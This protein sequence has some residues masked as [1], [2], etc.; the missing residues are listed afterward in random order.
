MNLSEI[1]AITGMSGL[2][3][4]KGRRNDG[5]IVTSLVDGKTQFVSG[6][7]HLFTTLDNITLYTTGEPAT[8]KEVLAAIKEKEGKNALPDGKDDAKTKAWLE[9]VLPEYD[10]EKVYVSDMK[11]LAKWYGILDGKG[12]IAELTS[13]APAVEETATEEGEEKTDKV[14]KKEKAPAKAKETKPKASKKDA[15]T[16]ASTKPASGAQKI[17]APRKAQ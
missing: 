7:T 6:R 11:K 3:Q 15:G 16:K 9:V 1:A 8:L 17:T 10:K 4:I 14:A 12:L 5:L 2:F 13:D